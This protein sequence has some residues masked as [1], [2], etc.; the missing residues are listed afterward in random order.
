MPVPSTN[1]AGKGPRVGSGGA[2]AG[3]MKEWLKVGSLPDDNKLLADL[4]AVD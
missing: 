2:N 3:N 1:N 4:K